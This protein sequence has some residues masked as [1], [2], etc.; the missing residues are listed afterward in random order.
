MRV[1]SS[2]DL[3]QQS[4]E[5]QRSAVQAPVIIAS[6]GKPRAVMMSVEEFRRLKTV[7][8]E[9]VPVEALPRQPIFLGP[10][11][12]DVLGYVERDPVE[13]VLH[14]ARDA[15]GGVNKDAVRREADRFARHFIQGVK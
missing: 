2:L 12:D 7:A 14:M 8:E 6:H 15:I 5:I 4:G 1:F 11:P 13:A 9:E 3:Q 10:E